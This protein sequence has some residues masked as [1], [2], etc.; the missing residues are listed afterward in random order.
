MTQPTEAVGGATSNDTVIAAEPTIEDRFAALSG[1]EQ[2]H[3]EAASVDEP[4]EED[5]PIVAD[6]EA[7]PE[8]EE[9]DL[10]P[11][12]P[13]TSLTAEEKEAFKNW[14]RDAQEAMTRRVGEL[15]KGYHTKAQEAA[16]TRAA[17]EQQAV[18]QI[19]QIQDTHIQHLT[20][21]LPAI[22]ERPSPRLQ[23]EDPYAYADQMEAH[24]W[25]LA[26]HQQAQQVIQQIEAQRGQLQQAA[27]V[28]ERQQAVQMLQEA[29]PEYLDQGQAGAELRTKLGSTALALGYSQD[30]LGSVSGQDILAMRTAHDWKEKADKYD[31]LISKQ[32]EKVREAKKLPPVSRP[33]AAQP[34]GA[35]AN[36]R[37]MADREAMR[38][39]DRDA[40]AR[41]FD[42][43]L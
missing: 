12:Q 34:K 8:A 25:A 43:F 17:V 42:R 30:Q 9:T 33:G 7:E 41:V 2:D 6:S 39:G 14:P 19:T 29:F 40:T 21:L 4:S 27:E 32:M 18:A 20:A 13:P 24:D 35:A 1:E 3:D 38:K 10:P 5:P 28:Q 11:I 36:Q 31:A 37:Y 15:E 26:Q 23:I 16:R 22:P